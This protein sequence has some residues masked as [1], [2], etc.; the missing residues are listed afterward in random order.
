MW[1]GE[2]KGGERES[3]WKSTRLCTLHYFIAHC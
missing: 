3:E 2:V 1:D